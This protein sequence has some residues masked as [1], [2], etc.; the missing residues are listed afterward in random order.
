MKEKK[1]GIILRKWFH[2][3]VIG[4]K[5][6]IDMH[7]A[8]Y[9]CKNLHQRKWS[10]QGYCVTEWWSNILGHQPLFQ[11][12]LPEKFHSSKQLRSHYTRFVHIFIFFLMYFLNTQYLRNSTI[13]YPLNVDEIY[14]L[15]VSFIICTPTIN[16]FLKSLHA[17]N[18]SF[19]LV[20]LIILVKILLFMV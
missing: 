10:V 17:K 2:P 8:F 1:V 7:F 5:N 3:I 20:N 13:V 9:R 19:S 11:N 4:T 6:V 12:Q 15:K 16:F 18:M 14:G